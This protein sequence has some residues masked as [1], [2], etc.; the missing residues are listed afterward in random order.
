[1]NKQKNCI[2]VLL[3]LALIATLC[4]GCGKSNKAISKSNFYFDTLINITLY[5]VRQEN[6]I[7]ECFKLAAEYE[8]LLSTTKENSD[9]SRINK[10]AG[11]NSVEV[12]PRT[13]EV[14]KKGIE[15][16][17][18]SEG[19]FDITIGKITKL[20][21]ISDI[22]KNAKDDN[23]IVDSSYLPSSDEI[24]NLLPSINY[25]NIVID[26]NKVMLTD[27]NCEIDLGAI[28]KGYIADKMKEL[29][30]E[31]GVKSGLINL[32]GNILAIGT[33]PDNSNYTVGIQKPFGETNEPILKLK[34]SNKSIVTSG[35]YE[36]YF[37][38]ENK[39]YHHILDVTTGYPCENDLYSVTII[40]DKSTDGDALST[41]CFL[42]GKDEGLKFIN[43]LD[44][45]EA[46]FIDNNNNINY[47]SSAEKYVVNK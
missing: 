35:I 15:Y 33:K 18:L 13:V 28:A 24:N 34:V 20:W 14:I 47:S 23:N 36:R 7:D 27:S 1:M 37:R 21:N 22:S 42:L 25:E 43:S 26:G 3:L 4:S 41:V 38:I 30:G 39:I 10:A 19:K 6:L 40:S 46:I 2:V 16:S 17:E 8:N 31:N 11:I 9:I 29:L 45:I 12:D 44:D 32:G 5:D